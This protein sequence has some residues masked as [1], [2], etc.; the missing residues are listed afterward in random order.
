LALKSTI[1]KAA[2]QVAD[3]DRHYYADHALTI[4]CH[5][6]ETAERMMVRV[7]AFALNAGE[8][9]A[10]GRGLSDVAEPDLVEADLTGA[11]RHWIE[12]GQP[13][14][15]AVLKACGKATRVTVYPYAASAAKWWKDAGPELARARNLSVQAIDAETARE[16]SGMA[17]RSMDLQCTIQDGEVWLRS[18]NAQVQVELTAW[19][20]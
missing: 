8:S 10:F 20:T 15:R 16:L 7:L 12:V 2:L 13:D 1:Y 6:S 3:M 4:A 5:P 17:E 19:R 18:A 9:L 14:P 11:I